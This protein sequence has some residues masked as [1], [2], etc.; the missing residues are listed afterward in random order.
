MRSVMNRRIYVHAKHGGRRLISIVVLVSL[1]LTASSSAHPDSAYEI[2]KKVDRQVRT[3]SDQH[4]GS[5]E[6]YERNGKKLKKSWRV[7]PKGFC[8]ESKILVRFH[9]TPGGKGG[10]VAV[11]RPGG[12]PH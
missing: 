4:R 7:R 8:N 9:R 6:V 10:G 3:S 2:M 12:G 1:W 11:H 5:L